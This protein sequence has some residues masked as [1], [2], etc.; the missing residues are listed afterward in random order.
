MKTTSLLLV[1]AGLLSFHHA[2]NAQTELTLCDNDSLSLV[3]TE[4]DE[5][6]DS[7]LWTWNSGAVPSVWEAE[8]TDS[9]LTIASASAAMSGIYELVQYTTAISDTDTVVVSSIA[10][11][12]N[13][14]VLDPFQLIVPDPTL[15]I[16]PEVDSTTFYPILTTG[17]SGG[18]QWNWFIQTSDSTY[19]WD[20]PNSPAI[21]INAA[22]DT[23][24][25]FAV[26]MDAQ[27]CGTIEGPLLNL[28]ILDGIEA[29][30]LSASGSG[31]DTGFCFGSDV[32]VTSTPPFTNTEYD[33]LWN[34]QDESGNA[35]QSQQSG[36]L[37][38]TIESLEAAATVNVTYTT[39]DGCSAVE[40]ATLEIPVLP[41]LSNVT[42][43]W[44]EAL[45]TLCYNTAPSTA[46]L[47]INPNEFTTMDWQWNANN[48]QG[49]EP[50]FGATTTTITPSALTETTSFS[51]SGVSADGCGAVNSNLLIAEVFPELEAPVIDFE[52]IGENAPICFGSETP[53]LELV[54]PPAT[55][56]EFTWQWEAEG[57]ALAGQNAPVLEPVVLETTTAFQLAATSTD[58]C[59]TVTSNAVPVEVLPEITPGAL[60]ASTDTICYGSPAFLTSTTPTGADG[61]FDVNWF[62]G[63]GSSLN[64][65][66]TWQG[67]EQ[68][69]PNAI[70]SFS[71]YVEYE[72]Q[73]GCGTVTSDT[74]NVHVYEALESGM[75]SASQSICFDTSPD[76]LTLSSASGG[77][78][79]F[80]YTWQILTE[81]AS[82]PSTGA[83][84][85]I[86]SPGPLLSTM[87]VS[88]VAESTSGCGSVESNTIEIYV[89]EELIAGSITTLES[90]I[91]Y[92]FTS[93]FSANDAPSGEN[94]SY[95]WWLEEPGGDFTEIPGEVSLSGFSPSLN[96]TSNLAITY[97]SEDGCGTVWSEPLQIEVL[98]QLQAP[99]I[100]REGSTET[101]CYGYTGPTI[102]NALPATGGTESF[103]YGWQIQNSLQNW[104]TV[105][106][107][108]DFFTF[109]IMTET[110]SVR[111]VANSNAGCGVVIS[112]ELTIEVY[113]EITSGTAS[114]AQTLC[115]GEEAYALSTTNTIGANGQFSYQWYAG[116]PPS[117]LDAETSQT[118]IPGPLYETTT[119]FV[120]AASDIG[121]GAVTSN[122]IEVAVW[123]ELIAGSLSEGNAD[124]LCFGS[125]AVFNAN[126]EISGNDM[127]Y[128]WY[129]G[130]YIEN[131]PPETL[132]PIA[133][134][135]GLALNI[136]DFNVSFWLSLEYISPFGCGSE[137]AV[138]V[139]YH[140]LPEM[141][142]PTIILEG[143]IQDT[144]ICFGA[145]PPAMIQT[146]GATGANGDF[147]YVW[148]IS[149][150]G[151]AWSLLD[152]D[153][154]TI[155][156]A[157]L[158]WSDNFIR[159]LGTN[160]LCGSVASENL[161]VHVYDEFV[162]SAAGTSQS[163]CFGSTPAEL[164]GLGAQG[165]GE[166]Y[167]YQWVELLVGD[168][169]EILEATETVWSGPELYSD[170]AYMLYSESS[171]G[172]GAGFSDVITINVADSMMAG[173]IQIDGPAE[174]CAGETVS[175]TAIDATGGLEGFSTNWYYSNPDD[176][177][178]T[179]FAADMLDA[180]TPTL[181]DSTL[182]YLEYINA[183]G[184]VVSD[185]ALAIVNPLP[186][187]P[188]A[189]G[190]IEPC[191]NS[192][193]NLIEA[194]PFDP[195]L[196]YQWE[197]TTSNAEITSGE[198]G[199]QILFNVD[200]SAAELNLTF[201]LTLENDS[202]TCLNDTVYQITTSSDVAPSLG[203]VIKK[204]G[205]NILVCSDSSDCA[206]YS[207]GAI[208]IATG[209]EELFENG[210]EQYIFIED[211]D[212]ESWYYFVDVWYDCGDGPGCITR[213][214]YNYEP[215]LEIVET[216][217]LHF[218]VYPNPAHDQLNI[219]SSSMWTL[220]WVTNPMGQRILNFTMNSKSLD[221]S[222]LPAGLYLLTLQSATD[223]IST[224]AFIREQ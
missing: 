82:E 67:L 114:G 42:I 98:P 148:E 91:C 11:A 20:N 41:A 203:E 213:M 217:S 75:L 173:T 38:I 105:S 76:P 172:C 220:G 50:I 74:I 55:G 37:G 133:G 206:Q 183:C 60:S 169:L 109:G 171:V 139:Y 34:V 6:L 61:N 69:L 224:R 201:L 18:V 146:S 158:L 209:Q 58:G 121:C 112:N 200:S 159:N 87:E 84:G 216:E 186:S 180:T 153:T 56:M 208:N 160:P 94:L 102:S 78:G 152:F 26:A 166:E 215:F 117:P 96:S 138:P 14:S 128:Q 156:L 116:A 19:A 44:D 81:G 90:P 137:F 111:L 53:T 27:G 150:N 72:S 99:E 5:G 2:G 161:F 190:S 196:N 118:L 132:T 124:T 35:I 191:I 47:V 48:G 59:G 140:V 195:G 115:F 16:C 73:Y 219:T 188:S 192:S 4:L 130:E 126:P 92:G 104:T 141:Q 162:P 108:P 149:S 197:S 129:L 211:L 174:Y 30:T 33:V 17:G 62:Y 193:D 187:L 145:T 22:S 218:S 12:W 107:N 86:W 31:N 101:I 147:S 127:I 178:W 29:G 106:T 45:S 32:T 36:D 176:L 3:A 170:A 179:V 103:Q 52:F 1:A 135:N 223:K 10:A 125:S 80:E 123:D 40:L 88:V 77:N 205:I 204:P 202:T 120:V 122:A 131:Q 151:D 199:H 9:A 210:D 136:D 7:L 110:T 164:E 165:G 89:F 95:Q 13:V 222:T 113:D 212:P 71:T 70:E 15:S 83:Y 79:V 168:T 207:W 54:T 39:D 175:W 85:T 46:S 184:T 24:S 155:Q 144:S 185:E 66:P 214:Y 154:D 25:Y 189:V 134:E 221:V 142:S 68:T 157:E 182:V 143:G 63:T 100:I 43:A 163:I 194:F 28:D 198:M 49:S 177:D 181:L 167:T 8:L 119:F 97:T 23:A 21:A 65:L 57:T 51:L 93:A 64:Y